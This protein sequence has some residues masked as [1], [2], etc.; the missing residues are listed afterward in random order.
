MGHFWKMELYRMLSGKSFWLSSIGV[1]GVLICVN[2]ITPHA[3][4]IVSQY[5]FNK[6]YTLF[7]VVF[8]FGSTA[9]ANS[10]WE[11]EEHK[12]WQCLLIRG[13]LKK[14]IRAKVGT[15]FLSGMLSLLIGQTAYFLIFMIWKPLLKHAAENSIGL[16]EGSIFHT[17]VVNGRPFLY[18]FLCAIWL[19]FL[20]GIMALISMWLTLIVRNRMFSICIPLAGYYF[21]I[22][23]AGKIS[24]DWIYLDLNTIYFFAADIC[25]AVIPSVLYEIGLTILLSGVFAFLIKEKVSRSVRGVSVS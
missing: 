5:Y 6:Y 20:G 4:D 24:G 18:L 1:L 8:A 16:S 11:D 10:L 17:F 2:L 15:G 25:E 22:S 19:G 7:I 23:Y 14:Y 21:C 12:Y 9:Y 13:N 3:E